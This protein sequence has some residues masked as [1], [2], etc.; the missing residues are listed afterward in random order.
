MRYPKNQIKEN[1]YTSGGEFVLVDSGKIYTGYY[2][3]FKDNYYV[4]KAPNNNNNLVQIKKIT[5]QDI[6]KIEIKNRISPSAAFALG[7][8]VI[9]K[10]SSITAFTSKV[11]QST[12][13]MRYF[14]KKINETPFIIKEIDQDTFDTLKTNPFYQ[15][16]SILGS[17]IFPGSKELDQANQQ[18]LGLK[19]FLGIQ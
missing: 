9:N 8:N 15:T 18:M 1:Q 3:Q 12:D 4:G 10:L 5:P 6:K 14:S 7:N 13:E 16:T 2:W 11:P 19:A 17:L